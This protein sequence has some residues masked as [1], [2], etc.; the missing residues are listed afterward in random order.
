MV[1]LCVC[2]ALCEAQDGARD[3]YRTKAQLLANFASFVV[4][5]DTPVDAAAS[6]FLICVHGQFQFGTSLA[7][8]TRGM[9]VHGRRIEVRWVQKDPELRSC[10]IVFVSRT[11]E[12]R[13]GKI[14]D[15]LK[16]TPVLTV[17]ETANFLDAGGAIA[18][19]MRQELLQFDVNLAASRE[20]HL[21]IGSQILSL[22]HR[23]VNAGTENARS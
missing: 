8:A 13:Y 21:R 23:V 4:W 2:A 16:G 12:K 9:A 6:H 17:G 7:E 15:G 19:L 10:Q 1:G 22:A 18:L 14:L 11:E 3:E 5:P 20:A